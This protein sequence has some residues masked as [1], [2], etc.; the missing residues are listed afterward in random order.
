[1]ARPPQRPRKILCT[2]WFHCLRGRR[3]WKATYDRHK[4][5]A[6][7]RAHINENIL[8]DRQRLDAPP[9]DDVLEPE[10]I[11]SSYEN[12]EDN[13]IDDE[14]NEHNKNNDVLEDSIARLANDIT[15]DI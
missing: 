9:P 4:V 12:S 15:I 8:H 14:M 7:R 10:G 1:M 13:R 11:T 3:V 2:C 5:E 6:K